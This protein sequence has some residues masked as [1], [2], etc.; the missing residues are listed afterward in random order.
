MLKHKTVWKYR[1]KT[2]ISS[3]GSACIATKQVCVFRKE[4]QLGGF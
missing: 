1:G 2:P 3:C 4:L